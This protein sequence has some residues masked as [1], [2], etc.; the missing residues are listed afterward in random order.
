MLISALQSSCCSS[1]LLHLG[2]DLA[3]ANLTLLQLLPPCDMHMFARLQVGLKQHHFQVGLLSA[4][5]IFLN[6][7]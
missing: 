1:P 6:S 5:I 4:L 3:E 2:T 7:R